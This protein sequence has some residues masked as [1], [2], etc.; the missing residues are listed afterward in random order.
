MRIRTRETNHHVRLEEGRGSP[1]P[2]LTLN[3]PLKERLAGF[4]R[5]DPVVVPRGDVPAHQ[6]QSLG[7]GVEHVFALGLGVLHN[8]AGAVVIQFPDRPAAP[9]DGSGRVEWWRVKSVLVAIHGGTVAP[10]GVRG[11]PWAVVVDAVRQGG[12]AG[13]FRLDEGRT[14]G[15]NVSVFV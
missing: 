13:G 5:R 8:G 2:K 9:E 10:A 7:H 14:A 11:A 4:T 3:R 12:R 1:D 6:T 15:V